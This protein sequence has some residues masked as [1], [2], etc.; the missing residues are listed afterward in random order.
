MGMVRL[1]KF[2]VGQKV[3][4]VG[5]DN[6]GIVGEVIGTNVSKAAWKVIVSVRDIDGKLS[7]TEGREHSWEAVA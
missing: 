7:F 5:F 3:I 6:K 2:K 4:G 1:P